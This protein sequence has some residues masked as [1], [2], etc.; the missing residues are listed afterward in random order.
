MTRA[1]FVQTANGKIHF[2]VRLQ[3][4]RMIYRAR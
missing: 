1:L 3:G 4:H 2:R